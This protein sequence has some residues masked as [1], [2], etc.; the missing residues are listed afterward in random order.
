VLALRDRG[1]VSRDVYAREKRG[2]DE[3]IYVVLNAVPAKLIPDRAPEFH[4]RLADGS[5][6]SQRPDGAEIVAA[7]RRARAAPDGTVRPRTAIAP[8][9]SSMNAPPCLT[10]FSP[11]LNEVHRQASDLR[12]SAADGRAWRA[13]SRFRLDNQRMGFFRFTSCTDSQGV[14]HIGKSPISAGDKSSGPGV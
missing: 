11:E 10:A 9:L 3:W 4:T 6:A 12:R 2:H 8:R 7:M 1:A 5:I 13:P 14:S